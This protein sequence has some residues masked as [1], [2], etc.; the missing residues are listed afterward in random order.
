ME[1][2]AS[3]WWVPDSSVQHLIPR[4]RQTL[5]YVYSYFLSYGETLA[6]MEATRPGA[7]HLSINIK[8]VARLK[9]GPLRGR[10]LFAL[11]AAAFAAAWLFGATRRSLGFLMRAGF[12][13]GLAAGPRRGAARD[14][15]V[16]PHPNSGRVVR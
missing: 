2:G 13:A 6:Y 7:N 8:D 15:A 11:N 3:G 1:A 4:Q 9:G 12:Y 10:L 5:R 16:R 14:S